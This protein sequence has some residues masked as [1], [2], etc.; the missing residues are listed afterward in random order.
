MVLPLCPAPDHTPLQLTSDHTLLA[1]CL[2]GLASIRATHLCVRQQK[3]AWGKLRR[4]RCLQSSTAA[5]QRHCRH[6]IPR[7]SS[8]AAV[9][10]PHM[11]RVKSRAQGAT[12]CGASVPCCLA[13]LGGDVSS[14]DRVLY[15][16]ARALERQFGTALGRVTPVFL[17]TNQRDGSMVLGPSVLKLKIA[18]LIFEKSS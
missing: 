12:A 16:L 4:R 8:S 7:S 13:A 14:S 17:N 9:P 18:I 11:P 1:A 2:Q 6:G 15:E 10:L 5:A 3:K